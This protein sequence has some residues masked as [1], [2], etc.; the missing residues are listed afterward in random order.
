M[1]DKNI[2]RKCLSE[3]SELSPPLPHKTL[4]ITVSADPPPHNRAFNPGLDVRAVP[5]CFPL[6]ASPTT[7][8]SYGM[9]GPRKARN[10]GIENQ[11]MSGNRGTDLVSS[12][13]GAVFGGD[14][15]RRGSVVLVAWYECTG[16]SLF[17][18][19]F[20]SFF[21]QLFFIYCIFF[22]RCDEIE[23]PFFL[24]P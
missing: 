10:S 16:V 19:F 13:S 8:P 22:P 4:I 18:S 23:A 2:C 9:P 7:L 3:L 5:P 6:H 24:M 20:L 11:L 15:V 17:F 21:F 1:T 14:L 12:R